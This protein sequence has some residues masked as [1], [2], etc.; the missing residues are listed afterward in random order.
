VKISTAVRPLLLCLLVWVVSGHARSAA[1]QPKGAPVAPGSDEASERFRSGVAFYKDRDFEAALVEFKRAYELA[2]NYK[3]LFNLGQTSRELD[4]YAT[5]LSSF[6]QY[7]REGGNE[8][9]PGRRKDVRAW[10]DELEKKVGR[11]TIETNVEGAEI[12]VDDLPVGRAPLDAPVVVNVGR[13]RFRATLEGYTPA[14][15]VVEVAGMEQS[16]VG[17][18]LTRIEKQVEPPKPD[19]PKPPAEPP[20]PVAAW[21]VFSATAACAVVTGVMGGLAFSARGE[22]DDALAAF[23]GDPAAIDDAQSRTNTFALTTDIVGAV[24]IAGAVTTVILFVLAPGAP[25]EP[26]AST[27]FKLSPTG[28]GVHGTF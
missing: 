10:I 6:E 21:V 19:P 8:I 11:I 25:E 26:K 17:L 3:V 24:T 7:L 4:D 1:A 22:L 15:R 28:L 14:L 16:T 13:H 20:T 27:S 5:A 2:P 9:L 23:P 12:L 18:E